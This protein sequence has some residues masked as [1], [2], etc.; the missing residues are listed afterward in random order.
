M[1]ELP[2]R[3]K[4]KTITGRQ[5][6]SR[7]EYGWITHAQSGK[8]HGLA[9]AKTSAAGAC[10]ELVITQGRFKKVEHGPGAIDAEDE[11]L[12]GNVRA[13]S[14]RRLRDLSVKRFVNYRR[15][16]IVVKETAQPKERR[17]RP[18]LH[19]EENRG[20]CA[21]NGRRYSTE[22]SRKKAGAKSGR[23]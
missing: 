18:K 13:A 22:E 4:S 11:L 12:R 7:V 5:N 23:V 3:R 6:A 9:D 8:Q 15:Q 16:M 17:M 14:K 20:E 2:G 1:M 21:E 10:D 19:A